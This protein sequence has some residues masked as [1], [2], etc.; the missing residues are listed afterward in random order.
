MFWGDRYTTLVDRIV[1]QIGCDFGGG[2][3]SIYCMAYAFLVL[4]MFIYTS[5]DVLA[6]RSH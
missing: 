1:L 6:M 3:R 5:D 2:N 4:N